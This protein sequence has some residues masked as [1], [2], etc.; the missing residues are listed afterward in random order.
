M[1]SVARLVPGCHL[2]LLTVYDQKAPHV[3]YCDNHAQKM[4]YTARLIQED[5]ATDGDSVQTLLT[6]S[7]APARVPFSSYLRGVQALILPRTQIDLRLS[8]VY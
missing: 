2:T 6:L 1:H 7:S 4:Q 5:I 3:R 8:T